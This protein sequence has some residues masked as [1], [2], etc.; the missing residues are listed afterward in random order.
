MGPWLPCLRVVTCL[1]L[2][3]KGAAYPQNLWCMLVL[4]WI[5]WSWKVWEG[6][7]KQTWT[8]SFYVTRWRLAWSSTGRL[9]NAWVPGYMT[10]CASLQGALTWEIDVIPV[11]FL[12]TNNDCLLR[13]R[14]NPPREE[15]ARRGMLNCN[16][17]F[18][19]LLQCARRGCL[20]AICRF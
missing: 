4:T 15:F 6:E 2:T 3:C 12:Q 11:D 1:S 17:L 16:L 7:L 20:I 19:G 13:V 8:H 18:L 10:V 9:Q 14:P 5:L